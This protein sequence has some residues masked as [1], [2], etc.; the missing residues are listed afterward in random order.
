M[1]RSKWI[2]LT[3]AIALIGMTATGCSLGGS[4]NSGAIDPPPAGEPTPLDSVT[5]TAAQV[6]EAQEQQQVT[7]YFEDA[8]GFV[9]PV[10]MNLPKVEWVGKQALSYMV[11]GGPGEAALP[12]GFRSLLPA[13][14]EVKGMNI[15]AEQKLATVNFSQAFEQYAKED[16]RKILE[17]ITWTLTSFPTIDKVELWVEGHPLKQM[18]VAGTPLDAPLS[19]IMG[20]NL[21]RSPGVSVGQATP[22]T[23]Y[24][25]GAAGDYRYLVPV[26]RLIPRTDNLAEAVMQ[27][28]IAGPAENSNLSAVMLPDVEVLDLMV[29]DGLVTVDLSEEVRGPDERVPAESL[30]AVVMSLSDSL[31]AEQVQIMVAGSTQVISTEEEAYTLPV[32]RPVHLNKL[33]F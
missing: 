8:N 15:D 4:G 7:L 20:I 33:E 3:L 28:L 14:T 18:P 13:G 32:N 9:A 11:E 29:Q 26:T 1:K 16:E 25:E 10:T 2:R 31:E 27:Q 19:R 23:V 24:F 5:P 17:A 21:E 30:R 6:E 12:A 22:V